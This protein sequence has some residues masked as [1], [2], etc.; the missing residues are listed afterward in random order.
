M[1]PNIFLIDH[2]CKIQSETS[3]TLANDR[4]LFMFLKDDI[5]M[6]FHIL[7]LLYLGFLLGSH[8]LN[9]KD[10]KF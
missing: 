1:L 4:I 6:Y 10:P 3:K 5:A 2:H 8:S 9:K 7:I